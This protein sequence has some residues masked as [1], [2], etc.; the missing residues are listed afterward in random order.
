M[1]AFMRLRML[2]ALLSFEA[3]I[4]LGLPSGAHAPR[5]EPDPAFAVN[6]TLGGKGYV[7]KVRP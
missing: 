4:S 1:K 6:V 7:N 5:A 3:G 2:A